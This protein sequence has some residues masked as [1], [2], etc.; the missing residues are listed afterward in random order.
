MVDERINYDENDEMTDEQYFSEDDG[1]ELTEDDAAQISSDAPQEPESGE[2][3]EEYRVSSI[4]AN[5]LRAEC[6]IKVEAAKTTIKFSYRGEQYKGIVLRKLNEDNYIFLVKEL[7][8]KTQH[9]TMKKIY[10]P[11]AELI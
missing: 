1:R 11:D 10:I 9:M 2:D 7:G 3:E 5:F 6:Q 8:K 4:N